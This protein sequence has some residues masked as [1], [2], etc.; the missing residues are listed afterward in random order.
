MQADAV[1]SR[2]P[3]VTAAGQN[4]EFTNWGNLH[5]CAVM[6]LPVLPVRMTI[7][8]ATNQCQKAIAPLNS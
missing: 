6:F 5:S 4:I 2:Q 7:T 3:P 8:D 1:A